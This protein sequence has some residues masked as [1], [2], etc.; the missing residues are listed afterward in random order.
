MRT[1]N[2]MN[3]LINIEKI[4]NT[5]NLLFESNENYIFNNVKFE[6]FLNINYN[7]FYNHF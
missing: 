1:K 6:F 7:L 3:Y 4:M 2:E 5:K